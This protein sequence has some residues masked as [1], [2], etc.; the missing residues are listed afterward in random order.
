MKLKMQLSAVQ[1]HHGA[2]SVL[3]LRAS[4][5]ADAIIFAKK[6]KKDADAATF[7]FL[8]APFGRG[9]RQ[10]VVCGVEK[11][12]LSMGQMYLLCHPSSED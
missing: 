8:L 10:E 4:C 11:H 7:I 3:L 6:G 1:L 2:C 9:R 12:R 5:M